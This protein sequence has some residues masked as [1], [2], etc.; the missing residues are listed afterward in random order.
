MKTVHQFAFR[1]FNSLKILSLSKNKIIVIQFEAFEGLESLRALDLTDNPL[2]HILDTLRNLH[3]SW[4]E[5]DLSHLCCI[6]ESVEKCH[7][8]PSTSA[9]S[10]MNLL[11]STLHRILIYGEAVLG[12]STNTLVIILHRSVKRR[13]RYQIFHLTV[14]NLSMAMYLLLIAVVDTFYLDSFNLMTLS[15]PDSLLCR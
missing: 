2:L 5:S 4:F 12:I 1:M 9:T 14:S 15:W 6:L 7:P 13:E 11:P 10:C 3:L 8:S